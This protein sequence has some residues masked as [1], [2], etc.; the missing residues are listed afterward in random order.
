MTFG[1]K[2]DGKNIGGDEGIRGGGGFEQTHQTLSI[3]ISIYIE[4]GRDAKE[5]I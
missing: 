2:S 4:R 5:E 1:V 3:S